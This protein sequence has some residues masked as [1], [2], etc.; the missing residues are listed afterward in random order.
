M[1]NLIRQA[2]A[3][4]LKERA[5]FPLDDFLHHLNSAMALMEVGKSY[6]KS[7]AIEAAEYLRGVFKFMREE[8]KKKGKIRC[9]QF[10]RRSYM[11]FAWEIAQLAGRL[12]QAA[13][14]PVR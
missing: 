1:R 5:N 2:L 9:W 8:I 6:Q 13:N 4:K 3:H 12:K 11:K 7:E 14:C 10:R